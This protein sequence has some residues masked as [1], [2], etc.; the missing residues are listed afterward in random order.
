QDDDDVAVRQQLIQS[1]GILDQRR[2]IRDVDST[3]SRLSVERHAQGS[4][5]DRAHHR[6]ALCGAPGARQRRTKAD[7]NAGELG[8][9]STLSSSG[10]W[11]VTKKL[12][13]TREAIPF[14][15]APT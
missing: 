9:S 12:S 4:W 15:T 10:P 8:V 3:C 2:G 6:C 5:H 14:G 1:I 7:P 11:A 13:A